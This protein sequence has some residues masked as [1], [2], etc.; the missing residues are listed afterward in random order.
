MFLLRK[1]TADDIHHYLQAQRQEDFSYADVGLS[2]WDGHPQGFNVAR[3]TVD[4]GRGPQAYDAARSAIDS[5]SMFPAEMASLYWPSVEPAV[6]NEVVVGFRAGPLWSLNPC[7]VVYTVNS[8][9]GLV[10]KYGFAYGTLPGHVEKGEERFQVLWD[11]A[12]DRVT[13]EIFC[14]SAAQHLL[15]T[16]GYPFVLYQQARFR[17]LSGR[18]MQKYV[19]AAKAPGQQSDRP[20]PMTTIAG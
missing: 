20:E 3:H 16:V 2:E 12:T 13:Y 17:R 10:Q 8:Q 6:G 5:W 4:L 11:L 9:V 19:A 18:A 15:A 1:P 7:R 14:F